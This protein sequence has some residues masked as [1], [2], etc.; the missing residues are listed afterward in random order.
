ML[1][2]VTNRQKT[3]NSCAK[4]RNHSNCKTNTKLPHPVTLKYLTYTDIAKAFF[5][6]LASF[7]FRSSDKLHHE[8]RVRRTL[9]ETPTTS[10]VL[11]YIM[12]LFRNIFF[13]Y[14]KKYL[15]RKSSFSTRIRL[16]GTLT[17][18]W[19]RRFH[20]FSSFVYLNGVCRGTEECLYSHGLSVLEFSEYTTAL[21]QI[22]NIPPY[23]KPHEDEFN[24]P[25]VVVS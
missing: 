9:S 2:R 25:F 24:S 22:P 20:R 12:L 14:K 4:L 11:Y 15:F 6:L 19:A 13:C 17:F 10:V 5:C 18:L 21:W 23:L 3:F 1:Y 8:S 16:L 7:F